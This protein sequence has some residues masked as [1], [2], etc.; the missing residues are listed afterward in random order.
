[1]K[2]P[3]CAPNWPEGE[4][5]SH[6]PQPK[7]PSTLEAPGP[8]LTSNLLPRRNK[9]TQSPRR[10]TSPSTRTRPWPRARC[11]QTSRHQPNPHRRQQPRQVAP[12]SGTRASA[13]AGAARAR[14]ACATVCTD[15]G[16]PYS[17][18]P[19]ILQTALSQY[20]GI[21]VPVRMR[22]RRPGR[23]TRSDNVSGPTRRSN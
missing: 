14:T 19:G 8:K 11:C 5:A 13:S 4:T 16:S 3:N 9:H 10:P 6:T 2:T 22:T 18:A 1:M 15:R 21:R 23:A 12:K 17:P 20:S 7:T